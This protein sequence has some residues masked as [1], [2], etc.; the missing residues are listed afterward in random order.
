M[1]NENYELKIKKSKGFFYLSLNNKVIKT[2]RSTKLSLP[3]YKIAKKIKIEFSKVKN[4]TNFTLMPTYSMAL[5]IIDQVKPNLKNLNQEIL[6]YSMND[7]IC[8]RVSKNEDKNLNALQQDKWDKW[9]AW[10][11][12]EI[13][14]KLFVNE[15][16]MPINQSKKVSIRIKQILSNYSVWEFGCLFQATK[17]S[18]SF[19][20]AYAFIKKNINSKELFLLSFLEELYQNQKWGSDD[21]NLKRNK[22]VQKEL[23]DI[24]TFL[25]LL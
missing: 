17:V 20:L 12:T 18:G 25:T 15:T 5:A 2:P 14:I 1:N 4:D 16:I 22:L 8:Y 23:K 10:A 9:L 6:R 24:E 13:G 3:S 11:E 21:D 7:L 19:F